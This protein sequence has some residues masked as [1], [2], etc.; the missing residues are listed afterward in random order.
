MQDEL[1]VKKLHKHKHKWSPNKLRRTCPRKVLGFKS[2]EGLEWCTAQHA[3]T[4]CLANAARLGVST[5]NT[6]L[7]MN[8]VVPCKNCIGALINAGVR[9]IVVDDDILYDEHTLFI[10][11]NS[12]VE[13]RRF[14]V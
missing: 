10:L 3:E 1:L 6:I 9:R 12:D 2:G 11:K 7:Y 13:I 14:K 5:L 4:N 8:Y